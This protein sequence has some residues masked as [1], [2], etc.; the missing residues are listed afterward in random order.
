MAVVWHFSDPNWLHTANIPL[1]EN[2][3]IIYNIKKKIG[4]MLGRLLKL[5]DITAALVP[6]FCLSQYLAFGSSFAFFLTKIDFTPPIFPYIHEFKISEI[7]YRNKNGENTEEIHKTNLYHSNFGINIM[8]IK[9]SCLRLLVGIF[10]DQNWLHTA[11]IPLYIY[12]KLKL[13]KIYMKK[14]G[15]IPRRLLKQIYFTAALIPLLCS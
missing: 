2:I 5:I 4:T 15:K 6:S 13:Y 7:I 8:C 1:Y 3:K 12:M 10:F 14:M 11:N 9:I